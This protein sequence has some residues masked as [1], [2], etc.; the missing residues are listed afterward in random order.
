MV[1]GVLKTLL[2]MNNSAPTK[3]T[4]NL[5]KKYDSKYRPATL[6]QIKKLCTYS[7]FTIIS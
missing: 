3:I 2:K 4:R 1:K 5:Q 7:G 6:E